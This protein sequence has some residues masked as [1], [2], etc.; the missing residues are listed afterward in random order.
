MTAE[1][2]EEVA[3]HPKRSARKRKA[4]N[5][6]EPK[7]QDPDWTD[8]QP[9]KKSI[10]KSKTVQTV[11][12]EATEGVPAEASGQ[13]NA[14]IEL[15]DSPSP[16]SVPQPKPKPKKRTRKARD[17]EIE[18]NDDGEEIRKREYVTLTMC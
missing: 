13:V 15:D 5:Y 12:V 1:E 6:A 9:K 16:P 7:E 10:K 11:A 8:E 17:D 3:L 14:P 4:V 18:F 2:T